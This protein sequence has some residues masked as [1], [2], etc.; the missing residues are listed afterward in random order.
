[1]IRNYLESI[2]GIA[3][4]PMISLIVF[5]LFFIAIIFWLIKVDKNYINKMKQ[6][7]F[8]EKEMNENKISGE[9]HE[10]HS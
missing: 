10:K 4:Y 5:V 8:E 3:V 9:M 1:M 2:D 6:L 7:P